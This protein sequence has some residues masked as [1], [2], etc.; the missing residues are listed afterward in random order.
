MIES[1]TP[2]ASLRFLFEGN[3]RNFAQAFVDISLHWGIN[4]L[5]DDEIP[6][7]NEFER[8]PEVID[9]ITFFMKKVEI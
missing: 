9:L 3:R 5:N 7:N 6:E 4:N 2:E 1:I 8:F